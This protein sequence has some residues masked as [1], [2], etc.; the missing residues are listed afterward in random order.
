MLLWHGVQRRL[1]GHDHTRHML[2]CKVSQKR[3]WM[4]TARLM[5]LKFGNLP[6]PSSSQAG[7][8]VACAFN[9]V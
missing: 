4:P 8:R 2:L 5:T 7:F 9:E 1:L 6:V 3:G